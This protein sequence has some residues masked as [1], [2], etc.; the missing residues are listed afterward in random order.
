VV[1]E[2]RRD[3]RA[4]TAAAGYDAGTDKLPHRL[5]NGRA[6]H[7]EMRHDLYLARQDSAG[8]SSAASANGAG[9]PLGKLRVERQGTRGVE[10]RQTGK[11]QWL[12]GSVHSAASDL[13]ESLGGGDKQLLR[14]QKT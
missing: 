9:E 4:A 3:E 1:Q 14:R 12:T 6:A 10:R 7:P 11:N 2:F 5:A 8:I 13:G